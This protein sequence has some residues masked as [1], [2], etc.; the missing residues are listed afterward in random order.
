MYLFNCFCQW[1]HCVPYVWL[2]TAV[3]NFKKEHTNS[4]FFRWYLR[5]GISFCLSERRENAT[6]KAPPAIYGFC[7]E[8][9]CS[10]KKAKQNLFESY[11]RV[12]WSNFIKM[13]QA[14]SINWPNVVALVAIMI[15]LFKSG[16]SGRIL[17]YLVQP[18]K[19]TF[20]Q[21]DVACQWNTLMYHSWCFRVGENCSPFHDTRAVLTLLTK[22]VPSHRSYS[23]GLNR[24]LVFV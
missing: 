10:F 2:K 7:V 4:L 15:C 23:S 19:V 24:H 13:Y 5:R 9:S 1:M 3:M 22:C 17:A 12:L 18:Q 6:S 11:Q 21:W 8:G 20:C 14:W 16:G